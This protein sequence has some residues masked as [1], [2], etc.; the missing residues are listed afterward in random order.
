MLWRPSRHRLD[1]RLVVGLVE[2]TSKNEEDWTIGPHHLRTAVGDIIRRLRACGAAGGGWFESSV[3]FCSKSVH[4]H[5]SYDTVY[6]CI[7]ILFLCAFFVTVFLS[8]S[9]RKLWALFNFFSFFFG[10]CRRFDFI[11]DSQRFNVPYTVTFAGYSI[12]LVSATSSQTLLV[13]I[14][15]P[16][17]NRRLGWPRMGAEPLLIS[18]TVANLVTALHAIIK[19]ISGRDLCVHLSEFFPDNSA[20]FHSFPNVE[21]IPKGS[22]SEANFP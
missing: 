7:K 8:H 20:E 3:A 5:K 1:Q 14:Y 12:Y 19:A 10:I 15:R 21:N 4:G 13:L 16:R 2:S 6:K 11:L 18:A 17:R 9:V 22:S